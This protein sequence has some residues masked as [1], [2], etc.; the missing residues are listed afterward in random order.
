MVVYALF[1]RSNYSHFKR[2][3]NSSSII[4]CDIQ[5]IKRRGGGGGREIDGPVLCGQ[6]GWVIVFQLN[7]ICVGPTP[8]L[9]HLCSRLSLKCMG[10]RTGQVV[11]LLTWTVL[12]SKIKPSRM[13]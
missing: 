5:I 1:Y 12:P 10:G 6:V 3:F 13:K 11:L 4:V 9:A 8:P 2:N 7:L